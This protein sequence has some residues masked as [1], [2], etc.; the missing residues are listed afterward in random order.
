MHAK[1][2]LR[3]EEQDARD[4]FV[5]PFILSILSKNRVG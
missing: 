4:L 5:I 2:E 3:Q 1:R